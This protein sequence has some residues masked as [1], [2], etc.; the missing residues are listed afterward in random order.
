MNN[1]KLAALIDMDRNHLPPD[2]GALYNRL[3]FARSPY[4]LQHAENPVD[5]REWGEDAFAEARRRD[6]PLLVSIGYATCHWCHVMAEE[7]FSDS[8][9]AAVLNELFVPIKVDREERPDLDDF[10]M[11]ASRA[12]TGGGGWPLNVFIDH[13]RRPF[14]C[15]TYL[16]KTPRHR[17]P[18]FIDLLRNLSTLWKERR[19]MVFNNALEI[20][21]SLSAL[22][23]T[24]SATDKNIDL[25]AKGAFSQLEEMFDNRY[26]GFGVAV[27]FPMP[28]YLTFLLSRDISTFTAARSMAFKTLEAMMNGGIH[29]LLGGGF[30]RYTVDQK[31]LVPHFEKMLYDQ[32]MLI[33][34]YTDAFNASGDDRFLATAAKTADFALN[35]LL[36]PGGGFRAAL[37]A[38]SEGVEGLFYTWTYAELIS[39]LGVDCEPVLEYWGATR[40]GD[41]DGRCI[42]HRDSDPDS[43]AANKGLTPAVFEKILRT[44]SGKLLA[45]RGR[46]ERPLTDS[47]VI[48]AWNGLMI[49]ALVRLYAASGDSRWLESAKNCA[50]F[51]LAKMMNSAGRLSRNWLGTPSPVAAFAED[52]A[53][54]C[55]GLLELAT[56][57]HD[58]VWNEKLEY[59]VTELSRLFVNEIGD[60]SFCGIDAEKMPID[61]PVIQDGVM[62][63]TAGLC[64]V[65]FTKSGRILGNRLFVE[66]GEKIIE[67]YRGVT[68]RNPAACL[69]LI[70]AEEELGL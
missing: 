57:S 27:K 39:I 66:K 7:S 15:T 21:R 51:I 33:I 14:F 56:N 29:D 28:I 37:D 54:F 62:P 32:A 60:V 19:E 38:D 43:F 17:T 59:F 34:A 4:L 12:L 11:T 49:A 3:I 42:L 46:R 58:P 2:G 50:G 24:E 25:L 44:A 67:R 41:L 26:F 8:E 40:D 1:S 23:A 18:G 63:S 61:I 6:V 47:K 31:W 20:C 64:A 10:Y 55:Y 48:C 53:N 69:T 70:M 68:E 30:H 9:V 22:S 52:Y 45:A 36:T 5:W 35:E 65:I 16:P 13:D